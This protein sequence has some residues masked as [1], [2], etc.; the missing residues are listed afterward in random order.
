MFDIIFFLLLLLIL[1]HMNFLVC[2]LFH[3][4]WH[5][6]RPW[7]TSCPTPYLG[8][9]QSSWEIGKAN[10]FLGDTLP[11]S[12]QCCSVGQVE[13]MYSY[14]I[15]YSADRSIV[16]GECLHQEDWDTLSNVQPHANSSLIHNS[17]YFSQCLLICL[18]EPARLSCLFSL[19]QIIR[20]LE[21]LPLIT[22]YSI[23]KWII[24]FH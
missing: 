13:W 17:S 23:C 12:R 5:F 8:Q 11:R 19:V 16:T 7:V 1:F 15:Y 22:I 9:T 3:F 21:I 10:H 20:W 24:Y 2:L 6:T 4:I 18:P 14:I